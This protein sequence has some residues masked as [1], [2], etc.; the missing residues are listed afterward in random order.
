M[1]ELI[2]LSIVATLVIL[3]QVS[4]AVQDKLQFHYYTSIFKKF[5]NDNWWNP[6]FSWKNKYIDGNETKGRRKISILGI[7]VDY[8]V[9]LT[10]G[11]HF[12]GF[13]RFLFTCAAVGIS[14]LIE[15]P[16]WHAAL[17]IT[18]LYV[19]ARFTFHI[20]FTKFFSLK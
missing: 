18:F 14:L 5:K 3:T 8:P 1:I 2:Y 4:K 13:L 9:F 16:T 19:K 10:D 17:F 11:W 7:K 15:T 6:A 12:F 20:F